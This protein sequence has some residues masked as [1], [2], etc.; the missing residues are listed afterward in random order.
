M[1]SLFNKV[2]GLRPTT[3]WK[4]SSNAGVFPVKFVK[5]LRTPFLQNTSGGCFLPL[6]TFESL[7]IVL[8]ENSAWK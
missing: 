4:R 8:F 6:P 3:L 7:K 1:E 2:T 5:F